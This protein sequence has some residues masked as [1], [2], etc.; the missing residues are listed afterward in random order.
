LAFLPA[1]SVKRELRARRLVPAAP[2]SRFELQIA[3]RIY[4]ERPALRK[5]NKATALALWE[6]LAARKPA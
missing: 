3:L 1:S 2:P 4:R 5:R 6:H